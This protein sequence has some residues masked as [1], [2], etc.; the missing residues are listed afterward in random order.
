MKK[1]GFKMGMGTML[2]LIIGAL[3][4]AYSCVPSGPVRTCTN[5]LQP[6]DDLQCSVGGRDF[7]VYVPENYDPNQPAALIV[8]AHGAAE[9]ASAHA[10]LGDE[11]CTPSTPALCFPAHGSGWRQEAEMP[12]AGFIVITPQGNNDVWMPRDEGFILNAVQNVKDIA[13]IDDNKVYMSGIS[14]G[15]LLS[16]WVGC[17][18]TD[19]FSGLAPV[20]GGA[21]CNR[22]GKALPVITFDAQPDFAYVTAVSASNTMVD[23]NNC[24]SGPSTW[25]TVD[26][27]YDEPVCFDDPYAD[28]P[29]LVPC[30]SIRPAIEPTVCKRWYDCDRDVEVVF[31]DVAPGNSHGQGNESTDAHVLYYNNSHLNLPSLAW[32]FFQSMP[33]GG[34]GGSGSSSSSGCN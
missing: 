4:A 6:G 24:S 33:D 22:V 16:Y 32:R 34:S 15:G 19:V 21:N 25:L 8:D 14:N 30:S 7:Y 18:N 31:C 29:N 9:S 1:T 5:T 13:N 3:L 11:Y 12:G 20:S 10:G 17:P 2:L 27:N 23:L 26:S 28:K